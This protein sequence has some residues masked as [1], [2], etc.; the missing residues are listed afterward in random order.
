MCGFLEMKAKLKLIGRKI[1][2]FSAK[3]K[4]QLNSE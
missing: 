4:G 2:I 1:G 3:S